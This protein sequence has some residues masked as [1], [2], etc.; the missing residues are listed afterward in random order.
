MVIV[1]TSALSRPA[2]SMPMSL[3]SNSIALA[4]HLSRPY[5][6]AFFNPQHPSSYLADATILPLFDVG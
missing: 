4:T 5:P 2:G 1:S 3:A 6:M